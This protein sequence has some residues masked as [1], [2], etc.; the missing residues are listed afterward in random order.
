MEKRNVGQG[1]GEGFG[2]GL[3][4]HRCMTRAVGR[5]NDIVDMYTWE[6]DPDI[7]MMDIYLLAEVEGGGTRSRSSNSMLHGIEMHGKEQEK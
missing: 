5:C 2:G 7:Y 4:R 3:G 1:F 6:E